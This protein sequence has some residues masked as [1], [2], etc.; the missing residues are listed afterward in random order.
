[1]V[2]HV[3]TVIGARVILLLDSVPAPPFDV[4][5]TPTLQ[6]QNA[7]RR[8]IERDNGNLCCQWAA[9]AV[10]AE[11]ALWATALCARELPADPLHGSILMPRSVATFFQRS[12]WS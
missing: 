5:V 12:T 10:R 4:I 6:T 8:K 11:I 3:L 2:V 9:D 1:V 7:C